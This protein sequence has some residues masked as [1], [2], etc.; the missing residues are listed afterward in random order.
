MTQSQAAAPRANYGPLL[1]VFGLFAMISW[2]VWTIVPNPIPILATMYVCG[3]L[4]LASVYPQVALILTFAAGPFQNDLSGGGVG[5]RFS[6]VEINLFLLSIIFFF[7]ISQRRAKLK[8][9][10]AFGPVV[11]YL[12]I[13][14]ASTLMQDRTDSA[15]TVLAQTALY[16][17]VT[18]GIY[19]AGVEDQKQFR[20]MCMGLVFLCVALSVVVLVSRTGYVLGLH[21]NGVGSSLATAAIVAVELWMNP[22][23]R[24]RKWLLGGALIVILA[25]LVF[26]LSRG[27]WIGAT[28]GIVIILLIRRQIKLIL[29]FVIVMAPILWLLWTILPQEKK[30]SV[31]DVNEKHDNIRLRI[32]TI[33]YCWR[34]FTENPLT[35]V[36]I[37]LRKQLDATNLVLV[38]LGETGIPGLAA[39]LLIHVQLVR[40]SFKGQSLLDKSD[41][42]YSTFTIAT[43]IVGMKFVHG[44]VDHYWGRGS[45]SIEWASVGVASGLYCDL[46]RNRALNYRRKLLSSS[47]VMEPAK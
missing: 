10:P 9:G 29:Q 15:W 5:V 1:V 4:A 13:C 33:N 35:G 26:S 47:G 34:A 42:R 46:I 41:L 32:A 16:L 20:Q 39:F 19:A 37:T 22:Q 17:V 8:F 14:V 30:D 18:V 25:G 43:A 45:L 40:M 24:L 23:S 2:V 3:F 36:G 38:T 7:R 28:T 12:L 11:L 31:T 21:K 27:A 44:C 6:I